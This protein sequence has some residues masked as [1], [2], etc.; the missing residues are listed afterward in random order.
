MAPRVNN[1]WKR[2]GSKQALPHHPSKA[3]LTSLLGSS[4]TGP[5]HWNLLVTSPRASAETFSLA[6]LFPSED[7]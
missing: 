6:W 1:I 3:L 2:L 5:Q 7:S 4:S